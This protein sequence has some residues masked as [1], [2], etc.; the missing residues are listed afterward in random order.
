MVCRDEAAVIRKDSRL[1]RRQKGPRGGFGLGGE[2]L[3]RWCNCLLVCDIFVP[4]SLSL[5]SPS[6]SFFFIHRRPHS[7]LESWRKYCNRKYCITFQSPMPLK[8]T[9][10]N[11]VTVE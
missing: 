9:L 11:S 4:K 6:P 5:S 10:F 2:K 3:G 8:V 1:F 7:L